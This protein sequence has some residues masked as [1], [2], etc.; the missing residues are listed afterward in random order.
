MGIAFLKVF[1]R[2]PKMLIIENSIM[3]PS[4]SSYQFKNYL[5]FPVAWIDDVGNLHIKGNVVKE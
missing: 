5:G 3:I 2:V 1:K 4:G